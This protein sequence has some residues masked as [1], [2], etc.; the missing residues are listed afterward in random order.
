MRYLSRQQVEETGISMAEMIEA[1]EAMFRDKGHGRV[2][3]PPKPGIHTRP[4][5]FI[6]AMPAYLPGA[7]AAGMKW[8]SG[9]PANP[10]RGLPY[11]SGL[12][13]LNDDDTGIPIAV[14][15]MQSI[16]LMLWPN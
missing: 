3:M 15:D 8:I 7:G 5:A 2:E 10:A 12:M 4:D 13:I 1:V 11:I 16:L 14:F 9:Y 6:H